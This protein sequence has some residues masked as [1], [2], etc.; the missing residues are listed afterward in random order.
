MGVLTAF[1]GI[2]FNTHGCVVYL[3]AFY[4]LLS[5]PH[6]RWHCWWIFFAA[7]IVTY[8]DDVSYSCINAHAP[9]ALDPEGFVYSIDTDI[10]A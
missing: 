7:S 6:H 5:Y 10:N 3:V 8:V 9:K 4:R 2:P 1:I